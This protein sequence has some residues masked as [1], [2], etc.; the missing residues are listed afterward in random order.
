MLLRRLFFYTT[1]VIH[2]LHNVK[3]RDGSVKLKA[4]KKIKIAGCKAIEQW[5]SRISLVTTTTDSAA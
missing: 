5:C 4:M 3:C 2:N 1:N